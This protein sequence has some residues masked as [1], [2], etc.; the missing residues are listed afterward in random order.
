MTLVRDWEAFPRASGKRLL[1]SVSYDWRRD[2]WEQSERLVKVVDAVLAE[3]G[4]KPIIAAHSFGGLLTYMFFARFGETEA[5]KIHGV[6][7]G[8]AVFRPFVSSLICALADVAE[9]PK[10][11]LECSV[12]ARGSWL[13][14]AC[15]TP[16]RA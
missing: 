9:R 7:Y 1:Y 15:S 2:F 5:A 3:T 12:Q 11:S 10:T 13:P 4:C 16:G 8:A 6:F 14:H